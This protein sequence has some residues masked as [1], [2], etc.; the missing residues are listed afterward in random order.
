MRVAAGVGRVVLGRLDAELGPHDHIVNHALDKRQGVAFL[1]H[2]P[3][4]LVGPAAVFHLLGIL[5]E[6][7]D[8][9][10]VLEQTLGKGPLHLLHALKILPH[11]EHGLLLHGQVAQVHGPGI[12]GCD[13]DA[14]RRGGQLQG[15]VDSF[16]AV[17]QPKE[18]DIGLF[19]LELETIFHQPHDRSVE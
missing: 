3:D 17:N 10:R 6:R 15:P 18:T 11:V 5:H 14:D 1:R 8:H 7:V 19:V 12:R 4:E 13:R 16:D 9:R 2:F